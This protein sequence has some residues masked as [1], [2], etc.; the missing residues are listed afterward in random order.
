MSRPTRVGLL[1]TQ[2]FVA[3]TGLAGG[4]ALIAGSVDPAWASVLTPPMS[5]LDGSPF[6]SYLI[7]GLLLIVVVAGVH[8]VGFFATIADSPWQLPAAAAGGFACI[9]WIFV[10]MVYIPFS[11]LQAV[12]RGGMPR[13]RPHVA[14]A[15]DPASRPPSSPVDVR[16]RTLR[17][18]GDAT[19][20]SR[21]STATPARRSGARPGR[22]PPEY[23]ARARAC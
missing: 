14:G 17:A 22:R 15:R 12:R 10:Q 5:Y 11:L 7:P 20:L 6:R 8:A 1:I 18:S 9:V 2:A 21:S 16:A 23:G 19:G 3:V 13:A 4:I